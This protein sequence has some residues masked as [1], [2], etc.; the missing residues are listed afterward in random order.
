MMMCL[1]VGVPALVTM[2]GSIPQVFADG[3]PNTAAYHATVQVNGETFASR[4]P[5]VVS[6]GTAYLPV[7][8]VVNA[9]IAMGSHA[10]YGN[11]QLLINNLA[12]ASRT[13]L[14][15]PANTIAIA[16]GAYVNSEVPIQ[17]VAVNG[18]S[19]AYV[20]VWY[21]DQALTQGNS[22]YQA[23]WKNATWSIVNN[24]M[25]APS[26]SEI[27]QVMASASEVNDST[28][29][30]TL[31]GQPVSV[32]MP[33]GD[34]VTAAIGMRSPT[35]DG[36]GQVVFFF[37]NHQFVGLDSNVEKAEIKSIAPSPSGTG[38]QVTYANYAP[39][40]PMV[41]PSLP[42]ATV[43]YTWNGT[44][45]EQSGD[46]SVPSGAELGNVHVQVGT[47]NAN[48][49][50]APEVPSIAK[51][52]ISAALPKNATLVV[53]PGQS[54]AYVPVDLNGDG[55]LSYAAAYRTPSSDVGL[56][57][58]GMKGYQWS[59][60]WKGM[61]E[62][63]ILQVLQAGQMTGDGSDEI[64]FETYV[65]DRTND[66]Y[67]LKS[68][69]SG[70]K[71]VFHEVGTVDIGDFNGLGQMELA[72]WMHDTGPIENIQMYAWNASKQSYETAV[73]AD[74]PQYF[75]NASLA[76]DVASGTGLTSTAPK[77]LDDLLATTYENMGDYSKASDVAKMALQLPAQNYPGNSIFQAIEATSSGDEAEV[78][79]YLQ[80]PASVK[81]AVDKVLNTYT[82]FVTLLSESTPRVTALT[83]GSYMVN[84]IGAFHSTDASHP[85]T[86]TELSF[87]IGKNG[88]VSGSLVAK[89]PFGQTVWTA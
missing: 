75:A 28:E 8:T 63:G 26:A 1:M 81:T 85:A 42:P 56:I 70:L 35:A 7:S 64:A 82:D 25:G 2:G 57:V 59:T 65:G 79:A 14:G 53:A 43:T 52:T 55:Q 22:G 16:N 61:S 4:V 13:L 72:Q 40:D 51:Q 3:A 11:H 27:G 6:K 83:D 45:F 46:T 34:T 10:T 69:K 20:P 30:F 80:L 49:L 33:N 68:L 41:D 60:L 67:V 74:F 73:S 23:S 50:K 29:H 37:H 44:S 78:K 18:T 24:A 9:L 12:Y 88:L 36:Y 54:S 38:F 84:V 77:M 19:Q 15:Q 17:T 58:V 71:A 89:D 62:G 21:I 87:T 31:A 47:L 48:A 39:S 66:V 32:Q 76:Y 5:F 86:A